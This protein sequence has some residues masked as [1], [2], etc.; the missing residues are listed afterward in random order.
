MKLCDLECS[1]HFQIKIPAEFSAEW[2][3]AL[4]GFCLLVPSV[5]FLAVKLRRERSFL[6]LKKKKNRYCDKV[7]K[8]SIFSKWNITHVQEWFCRKFADSS[9]K[10][11]YVF[12]KCLL[13]GLKTHHVNMKR[14]SFE[15][16]SHLLY[17]FSCCNCNIFYYGKT[18]RHI[19][20]R[21]G[22]NWIISAIMWERVNNNKKSAAKDH[23]FFDDSVRSTEDFSILC[24]EPIKRKDLLRNP[25]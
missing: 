23:S 10:W 1:S 4:K 25:S 15:P 8:V 6:F 2:K 18:D 22:K 20:V 16:G 7:N 17:K 24:N 5:S 14:L 11:K 21:Y 19:K 13:F 12:T 9:A 3:L